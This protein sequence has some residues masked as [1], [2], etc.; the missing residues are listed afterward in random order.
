MDDLEV[1]YIVARIERDL[2]AMFIGNVPVDVTTLA[3]VKAEAE[4]RFNVPCAVRF[5]PE[6]PNVIVIQRNPPVTEVWMTIRVE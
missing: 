3:V 4:K 1:G 6:D 2:N 5:D